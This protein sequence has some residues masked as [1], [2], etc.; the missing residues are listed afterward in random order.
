MLL[1]SPIPSHS[2]LSFLK[3]ETIDHT[4]GDISCESPELLDGGRFS[5]RYSVLHT[6]LISSSEGDVLSGLLHTASFR[7][8]VMKAVLR[9]ISGM[10]ED[11]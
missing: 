9:V 8:F 10:I 3:P 1:I 7:H 4:S 5:L 6:G 2:N 11:I